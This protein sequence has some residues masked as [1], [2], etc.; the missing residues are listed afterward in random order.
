[1]FGKYAAER[2]HR[3]GKGRPETFDF[4]GFTHYCATSRDGK[5]IVKR[6]TQRKRKIRKVKELRIEAR[7]RTHSPVAQQHEWLS[8]VLR[9][10]FAYYGL[11]S[12]MR[13]MVG[14]AYEVR[15]L[16]L[17]L[18][19]RRSQRGMTWDRFNRLMKAFPL[20]VPTATP[21][22]SAKSTLAMG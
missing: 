2:R 21:S 11:P 22:T 1:M 3:L 16:W 9:G 19:A 20:P 15:R 10:H 7:R 18:L 13:S 8:A 6:K 12:N 4:L 17:R 5:F 14:F